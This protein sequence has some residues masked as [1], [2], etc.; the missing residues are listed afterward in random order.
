MT[1]DGVESAAPSAAD[2]FAARVI[3]ALLPKDVVAGRLGMAVET[4]GM[5]RCRLAMTVTEDMANGHGI[6][7]G[8]YIFTLADT[9]MAYASNGRN[10]T[11]LAQHAQ[12]TFVSPGKLGERLTAE[13]REISQTGRNGLYDIDVRGADGRLVAAFRGATRVIDAQ[14]DPALGD[15]PE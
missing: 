12:I 7:H 3:E 6:C 11:A 15:P 1:G 13:A 5:G 2:A 8:G 10:R 4:V 9:A 14:T